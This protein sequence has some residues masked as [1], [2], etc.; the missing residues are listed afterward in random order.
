[1]RATASKSALMMSGCTR[2]MHP[3][4]EWY[5][6]SKRKP[7][8]LL[9]RDH[10]TAFHEAIDAVHNGH[11]TVQQVPESVRHQVSEA[12][13][14][15][16]GLRQGMLL[17]S[18]ELHVA[19]DFLA[20][21]SFSDPSVR[22]RGYPH[23]P[24]YV[25]GT[26]DLAGITDDGR[27]YVADWKTGGGIGAK[28][29]LMTL[30]VGFRNVMH[31]LTGMILPL[32]LSILYVTDAGVNPVTWELTDDEVNAHVFSMALASGEPDQKPAVGIYCTQL[33]CPHLGDCPGVQEV[34]VE[35]SEGPQSLLPARSLIRRHAMTDEPTSDA[36][37]GYVMER[38]TAARRQLNYYEEGLRR[39]LSSG[40]RVLS[41][42]YEWRKTPSG[43]R[44]GK[45][46]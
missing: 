13:K 40:G 18:S 26:A 27:I 39:Y 1:M 4:S 5:D 19:T 32:R 31:Q 7:E 37:A 20:N 10:G 29:Q 34:S 28:E 17:L 43:V 38:V 36:H 6:E 3:S 8:D 46:K 35:A 16:S 30:G 11:C 12:S 15:L 22:G 21:K 45:A 24:T 41:G 44:W 14:F 23:A 42:E 33:Y 2:W 25:H 9:A